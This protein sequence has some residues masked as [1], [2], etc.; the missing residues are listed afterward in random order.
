MP[1]TKIKVPLKKLDRALPFD[2]PDL[3]QLVMGEPARHASSK[4]EI[5]AVTAVNTS[6]ATIGAAIRAKGAVIVDGPLIV[7]GT[8]TALAF[9]GA[10]ARSFETLAAE[11]AALRSELD[12]VKR[13]LRDTSK[14]Y[15]ALTSGYFA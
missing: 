7:D 4:P 10:A 13:F 6:T 8:V 12:D 9:G 11:N 5:A 3:T 14:L 1:D 2:L 15:G